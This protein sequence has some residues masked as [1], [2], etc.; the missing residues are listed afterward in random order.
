MTR[1]A[2]LRRQ[3]VDIVGFKVPGGVPDVE[4]L[5]RTE[6][7][8][9][10]RLHLCYE[11]SDGDSV[12]AYLL[13]PAEAGPHPGI[14]AFHQHNSQ[15]GIG[16]SEICGVSGDKY[17]A[18]GP[19]LA[20]RGICVLAPD[21]IGFESR[22][23]HAGAGKELAPNLPRS[24]ST[25]D[26]WLQYYNQL[27]YRLVNGDNLLR[28]DL[29]DASSAIAVL[30]SRKEVNPASIGAVGHSVGGLTVLFLAALDTRVGYSCASGAACTYRTKMRQG[31]GLAM[32]LVVPGCA[33]VFDVDDLVRCVAPRRMLLVSSDDDPYTE[34]AHTIVRSALATFEEENCEDHLCHFHGSGP[35]AL[36]Q[37]RYDA[38]VDWLHCEA[39]R[40]AND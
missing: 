9:Y 40:Q 18:F 39:M 29:A 5:S 3:I 38:I 33:Q 37:T 21:A 2:E 11:V 32:S 26:G 20:R 12:E 10:I 7:K 13:V 6:Q 25:S 1:L 17:Q 31:T 8:G 36:D 4:G 15:W 35:H 19:A 30:A 23:G 22:T 28:K 27:C 16:K 14:V 34:D 24:G